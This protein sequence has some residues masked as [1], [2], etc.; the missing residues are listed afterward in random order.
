MTF[1]GTPEAALEFRADVTLRL[2]APAQ[3]QDSQVARG[4][5]PSWALLAA[6]VPQGGE[7]PQAHQVSPQL[8]QVATVCRVEDPVWLTPDPEF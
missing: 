3:G 2:L 5:G 7:L 4:L 6:E 1:S 8:S